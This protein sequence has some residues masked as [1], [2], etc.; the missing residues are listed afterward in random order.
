MVSAALEEEWAGEVKAIATHLVAE[1]R[2]LNFVEG[3]IWRGERKIVTEE[4]GKMEEMASFSPVLL[5]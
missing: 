5:P 2:F 3:F 4:R 1:S